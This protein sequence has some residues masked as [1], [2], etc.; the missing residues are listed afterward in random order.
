ME[1]MIM[2]LDWE[3]SVTID[4]IDKMISSLR[5]DCAMLVAEY[6]VAVA[7]GALERHTTALTQ[8]LNAINQLQKLRQEKMKE[9]SLAVGA[10]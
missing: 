2:S 5:Y 8:R 4:E 10:N 7:V 6:G 1:K 9:S 3:K